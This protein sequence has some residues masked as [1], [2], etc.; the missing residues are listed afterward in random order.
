MVLARLR[1]GSR[2]PEGAKDVPRA[3]AMG[4]RGYFAEWFFLVVSRWDPDVCA[5]LPVASREKE[6]S[7]F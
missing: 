6:A 2:P 4:P 5:V 3:C 1:P 7:K